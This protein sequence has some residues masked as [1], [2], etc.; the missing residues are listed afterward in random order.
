MRRLSQK[1]RVVVLDGGRAL[2]LRNRATPPAVD[3]KLEQSA[4]HDNPPTR[5]LGSDRPTRTN[6]SLGRRSAMEGPDYHQMAEDR[7]V[8][9]VAESLAEDLQKGEF[10]HVVLVA[11][12]NAMAML[13]TSLTPALK[14]ATILEINK[15][16]TRHHPKEIS[17][18]LAKALEEADA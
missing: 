8:A 7:F 18:I 16:L 1:S 3:L 9:G 12:P 4:E 15:D 11:P 5:E 14:Q 10:D 2:Y 17:V 6:D 13:R